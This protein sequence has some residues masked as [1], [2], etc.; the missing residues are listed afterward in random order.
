MIRI[1]AKLRKKVGRQEVR[2]LNYELVQVY[3]NHVLYKCLENGTY[4]SFNKKDF[5]TKEEEE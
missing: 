1:P 5:I 2:Y 4:E 3:K